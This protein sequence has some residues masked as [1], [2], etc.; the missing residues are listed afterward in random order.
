MSDERQGLLDGA[1]PPLATARLFGHEA[2]ERFL[3]ESYRS[4][5]GHHAILIEG[6]EGIG[7]AT[8][9]FRFAAHVLAHPDPTQAPAA[10]A[11]PDPGSMIVRQLAAGASHNL[12]HLTRPVDEKTGKLRGAIT[13]DEV[14]KAGRFFS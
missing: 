4:G 6:P 7:K 3:A 2:A 12:L 10:L 9:A 8:L 5:K 13:V 14:R 11:V 1:V